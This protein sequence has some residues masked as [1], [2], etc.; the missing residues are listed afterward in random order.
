[1]NRSTRQFGSLSRVAVIGNYL[2][3]RCGIA[4]FTTDLCEAMA[5]EAPS[6]QV[7]AMAINDI[8]QGYR[9]PLTVRFEI[10]QN[11]L[12]D[13][14]LAADFLNMNQFD[15]V[16][17][18]H[19]Y[20]IFGGNAGS[21]ILVLLRR[22][23]MPII[24]TLHTILK[25]PSDEQRLV[26]KEFAAL[27]DR[28]V[29][30]SDRSVVFLKEIYNVPESKIAFIHHG[31]P[32]V[33]FVDS[34]YY[35]D[36]F[37]V[38]GRRVILTFG[39]LSP[40][41]GI[42]YMIDALPTIVKTYPDVAYIILG[43]THPNVKRTSGEE[44]RLFLQSRVVDLGLEKHVVFLNGFVE[45]EKLSEF[46]GVADLYVTPYLNEA[47]IVSGTLAY[48]LGSG[49][50]IVSTPYWYAQDMLAD[51]RGRFASF[52][53]TEELASQCIYLFDNEVERH[54]MRKRA[55]T[56]SR[57]MVWREVARQYLKL[58]AETKADRCTK[59]RHAYRTDTL[60]PFGGE[61]PEIN[62][63]HFRL[64]TDDTGILQHAKHTVPDRMHGYSADDNARALIVVLMA[65][66]LL[67][68]DPSLGILASRYLSFLHHAFQED[69][70][71]FRNFMSFDRKWTGEIGS[72][73]SHGRALW[74]LGVATVSER[75]E[76]LRR[77]A[78]ELF[79][80]ALPIVPRF[81]H[82][83]SWA[84]A[85]TGLHHYLKRFHGDSE[86]RRVQRTLARRLHKSFVENAADD[87][88]WP[89]DTVAY[90][91]GKL[92]YALLLAG[93]D[94]GESEMTDMALR[95][96]D[97]LVRIQTGPDKC[98]SPIGTNGWY[99]RGGT[100]ARFDQ[101]PID[102]YTMLEA[103][104]E[105]YSVTAEEHWLVEARKCFEWFLGRN[106]LRLP[107]YDYASGGCRDGLHSD[108]ANENQGAEST[109]AWLLSLL[110]MYEHHS[111]GSLAESLSSKAFLKRATPS[112]AGK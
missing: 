66:G 38:E 27:S 18:Q 61:L 46:L 63:A 49:K 85:L 75:S 58:F 101:Q 28:L 97:W 29:V 2:P 42:E 37:E 55:Y 103:C 23:R 79:Q 17:V 11:R 70:G 4:T 19:E 21:H 64:L 83:R 98:F 15:L 6:V 80:L 100:K 108:R 31:I 47:Q 81:T 7:A 24:T 43:A 109:L 60:Q 93:E 3:R 44:Y 35:K 16:C 106:D 86:A 96:L 104:I 50:A 14:R 107:V 57:A 10:S 22:L 77:L 8:P 111:E 95:C 65:S 72:E 52:R 9:Y 59:P 25:D 112:P 102:V 74:A 91:N 36:Q 69:N 1:M 40:N 41:K 110:I 20:G 26:L 45:S 87:W 30:M 76:G 13:Y 78:S 99:P 90:S 73:D 33:A 62:L 53:N 68:D 54:A 5:S 56:F 32:D 51:K 84:F 39:L 34:N 88:L 82:P 105:A 94:L 48:A 67:P 89:V 71:R 12:T 92:P